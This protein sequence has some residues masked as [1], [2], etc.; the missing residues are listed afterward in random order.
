MLK[1]MQSL[2]IIKFYISRGIIAVVMGII[3]RIP[4]E[5][6]LKVFSVIGKC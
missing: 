2:K 3:L 1:Y 4:F 5:H 6:C